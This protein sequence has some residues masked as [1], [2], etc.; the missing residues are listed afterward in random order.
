M[1][2]PLSCFLLKILLLSLG[3]FGTCAFEKCE[4]GYGKIR[5]KGKMV[6]KFVV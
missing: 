2:S 3:D 4:F 6:N 5:I 1:D